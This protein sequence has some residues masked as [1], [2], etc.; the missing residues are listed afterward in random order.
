MHAGI[1]AGM[2]MHVHRIEGLRLPETLAAGVYQLRIG[3]NDFSQ[4]PWEAV[5]PVYL[6]IT[7]G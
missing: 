4:L 7:V 3:A 5:Q 1:H 6:E 2:G